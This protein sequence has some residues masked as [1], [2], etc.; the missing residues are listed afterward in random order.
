LKT[1]PLNSFKGSPDDA[2]LERRVR[3]K[4]EKLG[5]RVAGSR[6]DCLCLGCVNA[7]A[8]AAERKKELPKMS[9][10]NKVVP[11]PAKA[12]EPRPMQREEG[13]II[14][15]KIKD[16]YVNEKVGYSDGWTDARIAKDLGAPRAW[17]A[18]VREQWFGPEGSNQEIR[19]LIEKAESFL[20]EVREHAKSFSVVVEKW[21]GMTDRCRRLERDLDEIKKAVR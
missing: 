17:V 11:L 19:A 7:A 10:D 12:P 6:N 3:Q 9:A 16:V 8:A 5:W 4:F 14:Y 18:E 15:E 21:N 20:N 13:R 2:V 1:E